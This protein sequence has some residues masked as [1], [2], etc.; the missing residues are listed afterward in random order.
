MYCSTGEE[1]QTSV[2]CAPECKNMSRGE[3]PL[4]NLYQLAVKEAVLEPTVSAYVSPFMISGVLR[5]TTEKSKSG[6]YEIILRCEEY[7]STHKIER[8]LI[9]HL[10]DYLL[11]RR[12]P[13]KRS[14][15][16]QL[17]IPYR[18]LLRLYHGKETQRDTITI[19]CRLAQYCMQKD[20]SPRELFRDFSVI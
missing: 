12:F 3:R 7:M 1:H 5:M 2:L 19:M 10:L 16:A 17:N 20:I 11:D 13:S 9:L 4:L 6:E 18:A 8:K 14:L 15:A